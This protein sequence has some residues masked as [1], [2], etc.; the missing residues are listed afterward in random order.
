MSQEKQHHHLFHRKEDGDEQVPQSADMYG[1]GNA[2]TVDHEK[3]LKEEKYHKH[4]EELGG[5]GIVGTGG[6]ALHEKH[7]EKKDPENARRHKIEEE[8][9]A[10][11]AV[12]EGGYGFHEHH[13]KEESKEEAKETDG[14]KHHQLF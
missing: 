4:M 6:F 1:A 2:E 14:K 8:V 7:E 12:G 11:A 13:D 3:A 5:L 10:A 9:A